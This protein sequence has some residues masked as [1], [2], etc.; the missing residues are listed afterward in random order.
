MGAPEPVATRDHQAPTHGGNKVPY[1]EAG[2]L[3]GGDTIPYMGD[4][5][6]TKTKE[7]L[8]P[9]D[10]KLRDRLK[11]YGWRREE[12][13]WLRAQRED[14]PHELLALIDARLREDANRDL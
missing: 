6:S 9:G 14:W 13:L 12:L 5:V 8:K 11:H 1:P 3:P 10:K 2:R 4:M 7:R